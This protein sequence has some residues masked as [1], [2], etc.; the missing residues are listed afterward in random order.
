VVHFAQ[1]D[2]EVVLEQTMIVLIV[3]GRW[4][5]PRG[6][7]SRDKL[8]Q[9]LLVYLALSSDIIDFSTIFSEPSVT[10]DKLFVYVLLTFWTWSL[11]Q[12]SLVLTATRSKR[13]RGRVD[14]TLED[15]PAA[16][17]F[18]CWEAEVFAMLITFFMQDGPFLVLRLVAI[19]VF[20]VHNYTIL[21]F[22]CKN[23]LILILNIYRL[24]A[25]CCKRQSDDDDDGRDMLSSRGSTCTLDRHMYPS[26]VNRARVDPGYGG[27]QGAWNLSHK[28][29]TTDIT[30]WSEFDMD[31]V[32]SES[33]GIQSQW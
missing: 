12:F 4:L 33:G 25:I 8:S 13:E 6:E 18:I 29:T 19:I 20:R 16:E 5:L 14:P 24:A 32:A 3:I 22:I 15:R 23:S 10:Q 7:I 1:S 2:W 26:S 31:T 27:H 30:T 9:L 28:S 21:F 17:K 11:L